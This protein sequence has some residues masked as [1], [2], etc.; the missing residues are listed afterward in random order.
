L[1]QTFLLLWLTLS[2][3]LAAGENAFVA[4]S[5][6]RTKVAEGRYG[7]VGPSA[8]P[9]DPKPKRQDFNQWVLWQS[10]G[11]DLEFEVKLIPPKRSG[12]VEVQSLLRYTADYRL[13]HHEWHLKRPA[14]GKSGDF[15]CDFEQ[16]QIHCVMSG[17]T[18]GEKDH[19]SGQ[20]YVKQPYIFL[21]DTA[22]LMAAGDLPWV[23]GQIVRQTERVLK[24]DTALFVYDVD[25]GSEESMRFVETAIIV[26]R[27]LGRETITVS[28]RSMEAHKFQFREVVKGSSD[29]NRT[30]VWTT[31]LGFLLA[32]QDSDASRTE[33]TEYK[34]II[35]RL[36]QRPTPP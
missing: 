20:A 28:D 1:I 31:D 35:P 10:Q 4:D 15:S 17:V 29:R 2:L 9:S 19:F 21:S 7:L 18:D 30:T 6:K 36:V 16:D 24:R 34:E 32:F 14:E 3:G 22:H 23:I 25:D 27:Y 5:A 12:D 26:V 8:D 11:G 33:L 13:T